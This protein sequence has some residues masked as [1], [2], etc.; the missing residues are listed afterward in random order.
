MLISMLQLHR[1]LRVFGR[2]RTPL[3]TVRP[4]PCLPIV[5]KLIQ[6]CGSWLPRVV[7]RFVFG[8][9]IPMFF[10]ILIIPNIK[11]LA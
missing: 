4:P 7:L 10:L 3:E 6:P 9:I 11:E 8:W 5:E 1:Q 2:P